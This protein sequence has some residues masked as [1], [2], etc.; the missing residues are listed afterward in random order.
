MST[1]AHAQSAQFSA[2]RS[3]LVSRFGDDGV[4]VAAPPPFPLITPQRDAWTGPIA[5][6]DSVQASMS[7]A[8]MHLSALDTSRAHTQRPPQSHPHGTAGTAHD[9]FSAAIRATSPVKKVQ[10][11]ETMRPRTPE[12]RLARSRLQHERMLG[13]RECGVVDGLWIA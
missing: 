4:A 6:V 9:G 7:Q 12:E 8:A 1:P 10:G 3:R 13:R 2:V 11:E 5:P